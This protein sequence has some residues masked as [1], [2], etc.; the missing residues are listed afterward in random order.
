[1]SRSSNTDERLRCLLKLAHFGQN[2]PSKIVDCKITF[3]WFHF[4]QPLERFPVLASVMHHP[5]DISMLEE[6]MPFQRCGLLH[7]F[8]RLGM[9]LT[10]GQN[11]GVP[12]VGVSRAG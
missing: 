5:A 8:Q 10:C 12:K 1:M 9:A 3:N 4:R 7:M 6:Q 11:C 2:A